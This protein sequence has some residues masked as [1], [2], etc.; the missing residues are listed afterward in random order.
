[1]NPQAPHLVRRKRIVADC[2]VSFRLNLFAPPVV[3]TPRKRRYGVKAKEV[4]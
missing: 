3:R 1:M 2:V 4:L